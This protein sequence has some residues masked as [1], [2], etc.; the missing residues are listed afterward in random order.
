MKKLLKYIDM[1][2]GVII[3]YST[4]LV[5]YIPLGEN[6]NTYFIFVFLNMQDKLQIQ[7]STK[8]LRL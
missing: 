3:F 7:N 4:F 5:N 6:K 1:K 8:Y 2:I